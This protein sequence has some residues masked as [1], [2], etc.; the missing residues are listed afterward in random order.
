MPSRFGFIG[1]ALGFVAG[2]AISLLI[3]VIAVPEFRNPQ[4]QSHKHETQQHDRQT[5]TDDEQGTET[6]S[7]WNIH[8][9]PEDTYAQWVMALFSMFAT[10]ISVWAV[11]LLRNTLVTTR[12]AVRA[13]DDAVMVTREMG[14]AQV[15]AY[16][17]AVGG[18]FSLDGTW[19]WLKVRVRNDGQSPARAITLDATISVMV[20]R[21]K[22]FQRLARLERVDSQP[23]QGQGGQIQAGDERSIFLL[24]SHTDIGTEAYGHIADTNTAVEVHGRLKWIDVFDDE[25]TITFDMSDLSEDLAEYT[26][27]GAVRSG[28]LKVRNRGYRDEEPTE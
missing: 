24:W 7:F 22:K 21:G 25:G 26:M 20:P 3:L 23:G 11:V 10:G 5:S 19:F 16:L 17:S 27:E 6:V 18:E 9:S 28:R 2:V 12:E 15:R 4:Y 1:G 14:K 8:T 13:A